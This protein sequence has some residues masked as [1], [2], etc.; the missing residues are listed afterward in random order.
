MIL[1]SAM[2]RIKALAGGR[3]LAWLGV[4]FLV[5]RDVSAE[6]SDATRPAALP[7]VMPDVGARSS[8]SVGPLS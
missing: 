2:A 8:A 3:A 1:E 6:S 7:S 4:M 5:V